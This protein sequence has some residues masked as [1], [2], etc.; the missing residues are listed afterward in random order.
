MVGGYDP[1]GGSRD[2]GRGPGGKGQGGGGHGGSP[3]RSG[4]S[5]PQVDPT[6]AKA[7]QIV[8]T[9]GVP[10]DVA[11]RVAQGRLDL[12][13]AIKHMAQ[14]DEIEGLMSRHGLERA[15]ATQ[16]ALGQ[17]DLQLVLRRRRVDAHL[18]EHRNRDVLDAAA[19]SGVELT[20]GVH[21]RQLRRVKVLA[22]RAY[23]IEVLDLETGAN[24]LIHK[25]RIKFACDAQGWQKARKSMTWD[26]RRK[27]RTAEPVM[28]PQDRYGCSNRRLGEACDQK[29]DV[30]AVTLEGESFAG[31]VSYVA[32]WEF[33]VRTKAGTDVV[34]FRHALDDFR[35]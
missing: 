22:T 28:R 14:R 23:E 35:E 31:Q 30:V 5:G 4:P 11:M 8:K 15:L 27:A 26:D 33:G 17:A 2:H 7:E 18:A 19:G 6:R 34:I 16:I 24:E 29:A 13:E 10:L 9:T 21:G 32:R 12:N 20:I 1:R 3:G 25:T